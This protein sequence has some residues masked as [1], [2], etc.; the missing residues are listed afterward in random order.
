MKNIFNKS[1]LVIFILT[2]SVSCEEFLQ[3]DPRDL[4][5]PVN[6]YNSDDEAVAALYGLYSDL[7][8]YHLY[9][10][11][12][13]GLP[14]FTLIG[15]DEVGPNRQYGP[16]EPLIDYNISEGNYSFAL[17]VWQQLYKLI[18]DANAV[19]NRVEGN[20]K[21]SQS[22]EDQVV[23]ES[24]L[25]RALAYY[26]LTNL[27]GDVPYYRDALPLDEV[28]KLGR[29]NADEIR[30]DIIEDLKKA[31]DMLFSDVSG[32]NRGRG[33]KWAAKTLLT[34]FYLWRKDWGK[35]RDKAVEI[36]EN[37]PHSL[38]DNYEDIW[39]TEKP[40][41]DEVI[42]QLDF[43]KDGGRNSGSTNRSDF[44]NPR[45]RDEPKS[46][47]DKKALKRIL[48]SNGEYFNGFGLMVPLP[49]F[50]KKFPGDD[51]RRPMNIYQEYEGIQLSFPYMKKFQNLNF[52]ESP[53]ANHKNN[54]FIFRLADVYL[55]AAEAENEL[56]GPGGAYHYINAVRARAYEPDQPYSGLSQD[57]FRKAL[58]DERKWELAAEGY[59]K[60]DLIRWGILV[61]TVKNTE[62]RVYTQGATNIQPHHVKLPIPEEELILNP[63]LLDSD[64]TNNGYK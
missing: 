11:G 4:I 19:I 26:H 56:N 27:W 24:L 58:Q 43:V 29:Q 16:Y 17:K 64:P 49:D 5:S 10:N 60:Y 47:T 28:S 41:N 3:E 30:V 22:I 25:L 51:L 40:F 14:S 1:L 50:V 2:V 34:K 7:R 20:E 55:M 63:A 44:F 33:T 52:T 31:E 23:G 37:S 39:N 21:I 6:Y 46:S 13:N 12:G 35:A 54:T 53:R 18:A 45:L 61:E 9:G 42:W 15:V 48:A 57:E 36:I 38:L 59:R 8:S 32:I 62:F